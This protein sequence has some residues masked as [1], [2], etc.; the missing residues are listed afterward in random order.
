M[1]REELKVYS[2]IRKFKR[3]F[4]LSSLIRGSILTSALILGAYILFTSLEYIARMNS[5]GRGILLFS[6]I[7]L[8]LVLITF[9]VLKPLRYFINDK[10]GISDE[11]AAVRIGQHYPSI[12]D[13]LLNFLQLR[14]NNDADNSL[15]RASLE[16]R[17]RTFSSVVFTQAVDLR[18]N[19][20]YL[21]YLFPSLLVILSLLIFVPQFITSST[22]RIV[23]YRKDFAPL[24]PFNFI[25]E[26][27]S[28]TAFKNEDF[29]LN[30]NL[31][32]TGLPESVYLVNND[33][34]IKMASLGN[35]LFTHTFK[36]IQG[37][38]KI[39]FEAAGYKSM[40]YTLEVVNRPN[41]RN[42]NVYLEY[43]RYLALKNDRFENI[44]NL[45]I[46][47]GT[48]VKWQFNT[49]DTEE[50][51][52]S[53]NDSMR[54]V[55]RSSDQIYEFEDTFYSSQYYK[56]HLSNTYSKNK[57][58]IGYNINVI[59]DEYPSI[60]LNVFQDTVLYSYLVLGG[61]ISDDHGLTALKLN[62]KTFEK[63][64][65]DPYKEG[66][67]SIPINRQQINQSY[68]YRWSLD[69]LGLQ[70]G[71]R[72]EYYLKVWDNDGINGLK[73]SIS[74]TYRFEIP[75][76]EQIEDDIA[77]SST[78]T[79]DD[80][81]GAIKEAEQLKKELEELENRLRGK[82]DLNWQDEQQ[83]QE[84]LDKKEELHKAIEELQK[85]FESEKQ[86]RER[87][88]DQSDEVQKKV[89]D[90][91]K[92]MDELL[93]DETKKLYE[94]LQRLLD[95][96]LNSEK[97]QDMLNKI[98]KKENNLAKELERTLELFKKMKF[99]YKLDESIKELE[100][101]SEE[102]Q[103]LSE[104]TEN[105]ENN[106]EDL[107]Q[108]QQEMKEE[109][110]NFEEQLNELEELN[111]ELN[112]PQPL[113]DY[114]EQEKT[115]QEEMQKSM[116]KLENSQRKPASESQQ[117]SSQQMKK[118]SQ[119]LQQMQAGMEM[120]MMQENLNDLREI[121]FNLI[122]LSFDQE[123][124]MVEF[125]GVDQTD[126]RFVD[127]G[128]MQLKI[129]DDAKIVE[130]SLLSLA[131]R[132]GQ[133][134]AFVTR[135]VSEM[136][137]H[138]DNS[139]Q[140]VRDRKKAKAAADQQFAMTSMNNLALML[141]DVMDQMQQNLSEAMGK[142]SKDGDM[143]M[144]SLSELQ[145]QL[146]EQIEDLKQSGKSGRELSQELAKLA[147][148]QERIRKA[149]QEMESQLREG[150]G[151]GKDAIMKK[152]EETELD[153]V[154]KQITERT[155][156]RQKEILTRLLEAENSMRERELDNKREG[157]SA[158]DYE[159]AL[160]KAFEDYFRT[161]E[162]EVELLKT[163]PPKLY[164]YYKKEVDEYFKRIGNQNFE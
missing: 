110:E 13:R 37:S 161:K 62:Y 125:R 98:N 96:E 24:A 131:K 139:I 135:E 92:L 35:G 116:E 119:Q 164:P 89:E 162:K 150:E 106:L 25:L 18:Q 20:K 64:Q 59:K 120:Q 10:S 140:S 6:F 149:L 158:K 78:K 109:F 112:N 79:T 90:I 49:L 142:P 104:E 129:K 48:Q 46:P 132:A 4:Y 134:G 136:N 32:G 28:L 44:G 141:D 147:A 138:L 73:G 88:Q 14:I 74:G 85:Q 57:D 87:F 153:L 86:K 148:E 11:E 41:L 33:R 124:L 7:L 97:I 145:Q 39:Y 91:Q 42:F 47:E 68:F 36:K 155:I 146:N 50:L 95:E 84:L 26:D 71:N 12:S 83:L 152:M 114:S 23:N 27:E 144:P 61:N 58:V 53:F 69:S 66:W 70:E 143:K 17:A 111:Q 51:N 55:E 9:F 103:K 118:M 107:Q 38:K 3:K 99:D 156:R 133:M 72:I 157:I 127:L 100:N 128:Q 19:Q 122:K 34:K 40:T 117:K 63:D 8:A 101:L 77:R 115:I 108:K 81:E 94:E 22:E 75:T 102:Q 31:S 16:Q 15:V 80:M 45:E 93:D 43:P 82:N 137:S 126:P 2:E 76:S 123:E 160:P 30:L 67:V 121:L 154:N 163:V 5:L 29:E 56:L 151:A 21:T 130:D 52:I 65:K 54:I 105:K 1:N 113:E 60:N 159:N